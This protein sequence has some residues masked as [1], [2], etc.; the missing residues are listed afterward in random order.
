MSWDHLG[1]SRAALQARC[2]CCLQIVLASL[3]V[4]GHWWHCS[5][6]DLGMASWARDYASSRETTRKLLTARRQRILPLAQT[7]NSRSYR[8]QTAHQAHDHKHAGNTI[9]LAADKSTKNL[10]PSEAAYLL[11]AL[12]PTTL[13]EA[14]HD[15]PGV[16]A[17]RLPSSSTWRWCWCGWNAAYTFKDK[18]QRFFFDTRAHITFGLKATMRIGRAINTK[19]HTRWV[20]ARKFDKDTVFVL[21]QSPG[22][23]RD[24]KCF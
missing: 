24:R 13:V 15:V 1:Q 2:C 3:C 19:I 4:P 8:N 18:K 22:K 12:T 21:R 10:G 9:K 6:A 16:L 5:V 7:S 20:K 23:G 11:L 14:G 17:V